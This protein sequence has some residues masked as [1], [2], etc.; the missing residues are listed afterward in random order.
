M[1]LDGHTH[2]LHSKSKWR[3]VTNAVSLG[4]TLELA[5][6]NKFVG[7]M[8][9]GVECIL[10][11]FADN[12]KLCG[13]ASMLVWRDAIHEDHDRLK[14]RACVNLMEFNSAK[15]KFQHITWGNPKHRYQLGGEWIDRLSEKKDLKVLVDEKLNRSWQCAHTAQKPTLFW[16]AAKVLQ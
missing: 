11:K 16:A 4:L 5:Q 10:D 7:Y 1:W 8:D 6:F 2:K 3:S 12:T 15:I 9:S 14:R 13:V